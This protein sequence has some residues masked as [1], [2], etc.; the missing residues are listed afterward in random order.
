MN[1][2]SDRS[3]RPTLENKILVE[4]KYNRSSYTSGAVGGGGGRERETRENGRGRAGTRGGTRGGMRGGM[5]GGTR[6][7]GG[8][9]R[10]ASGGGGTSF[11]DLTA[12]D[13]ANR[14]HDE[15]YGLFIE[16]ATDHKDEDDEM[17]VDS[18][19]TERD[20]SNRGYQGESFTKRRK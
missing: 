20:G 13:N 11:I 17:E 3:K 5:R 1:L 8:R 15:G 14:R 9:G 18:S 19:F 16:G 12:G 6:G 10:E 7:G 2:V 4:S